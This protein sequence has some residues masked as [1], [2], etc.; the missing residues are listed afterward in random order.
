MNC[1]EVREKLIDLAQGFLPE[2]I[3]MEVRSHLLICE[4]CSEEFEKVKEV[5]DGLNRMPDLPFSDKLKES[6]L[7]RYRSEKKHSYSDKLKK[8]SKTQNKTMKKIIEDFIDTL[9]VPVDG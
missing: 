8:I 1:E 2:K 9:E 6:I 4:K 3:E 7:V 5:H